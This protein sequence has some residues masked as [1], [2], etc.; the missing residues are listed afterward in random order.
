MARK[1][2]RKPP[3]QSPPADWAQAVDQ[4]TTYMVELERS[5]HTRRNY[6]N[7][8]AA[9]EGWYREHYQQ[10][11]R[12]GWLGGIELREWKASLGDDGLKL[13][14]ATINRKLAAMRSFLKWAES[15]GF[16]PVIKKPKSIR[17]E[18]GRPHW[19]DRK[20]EL[21]LLRAVEAKNNARDIAIIIVFLNTGLRVAEMAALQWQDLAIGERKGTLTVRSGK[22]RKKRKIPLNVDAR[23]ALVD[24]GGRRY[25]GQAKAVWEGQRGPM[26]VRGLQEIVEK[27]GQLAGLPDLTAHVLRHTFGHDLAMSGTRL[28][29]I[30]SLMGHESLET[31]RRY[32]EPGESALVAAVERLAGG[33]E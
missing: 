22:G 8:L 6:R 11:L 23:N 17:E 15:E 1:R 14:P 5:V 28:E 30:A 7:D 25:D 20:E 13:M 29:E 19:L 31:T 3:T 32:V 4:F 2:T 9:F 10:V 18:P 21:A 26:T 27:Y 24:H 16:C 33:E 12:L